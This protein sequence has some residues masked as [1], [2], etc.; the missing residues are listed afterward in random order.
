MFRYRFFDFFSSRSNIEWMI[1]IVVIEILSFWPQAINRK[2]MSSCKIWN[3]YYFVISFISWINTSI[4]PSFHPSFFFPFL[5]R[6]FQRK[7]QAV[8]IARSS[9]SLSSCKNFNIDHYLKNIKVIK[10]KLVIHGYHARCSCKTRG[11]TLKAV[12]LELWHFLT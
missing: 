8:V 11:I 12:F 5:A 9:L 10:A 6:L 7:S 3:S 4:C 1:L 2:G